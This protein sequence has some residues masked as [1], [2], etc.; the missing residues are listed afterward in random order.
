MSSTTA[1]TAQELTRRW[2]EL[3]SQYLPF[4][5]EGSM[6]RYNQPPRPDMR[7]QGWKLHVSATLL[8]AHK[9]LER[10]APHLVTSGVQFKAPASLQEVGYLNSGV[11]Y[12]YTQVGK[13]VTVYPHTDQHAVALAR[14]LHGLTRSLTAP[15][16]PFDLRF[17]PNSN[18]YYRYGAFRAIGEDTSIR[19][20]R[21]NNGVPVPDLPDHEPPIW[22]HNPF[23]EQQQLREITVHDNP[24][25]TSFRV[26]RAVTQR[27]KGGVYQAIDMRADRPRLCLLKEGR[28]AGELDWAG[29]DGRWRVK[30]EGFVLS[31]LR[32]RG[33]DVP[34]VYS[35]FEVGGDYY[36]VLEFIEGENFQ[37]FL[38][39]Q[40]RLL[41]M[42]R[43]LQLSLQLA[44]LL[45]Q[46]HRIGWVWRDCK[47][48]NLVLTK[49]GKLKS[50]DFE[51]AHPTEESKPITWSTPGFTLA[52]DQFKAG[53]TVSGVED[54]LYALG[55]VIYLLIVGRLPQGD[56][57]ITTLT[58]R[59]RNVPHAVRRIVSELLN[60]GG[61]PLLDASF[62]ARDL[63]ASLCAR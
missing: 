21:D 58:R 16:I 40:K 6:W 32:E 53:Q 38:H 18:V 47:P 42:T 55:A 1:L 39:R 27:G 4:A 35:S 23:Y 61:T 54:D 24:L 10:I 11:H 56:T 2:Q 52:K 12:D 15:V 33:I 60:I 36:L 22:V 20:I 9:M 28:R 57:P 51:A 41:A 8:N 49:A 29:R 5:P 44:N 31:T 63:S 13:I 46:L 26:L 25:Q 14:R 45:A 17:R 34:R 48:S 30:R 50:L 37:A 43:V 59:R 62:V 7:P 3:C 19:L